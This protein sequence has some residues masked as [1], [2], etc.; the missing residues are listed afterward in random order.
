[1]HQGNKVFSIESLEAELKTILCS[2]NY[3]VAFVGSPLRSD[4]RFGLVLYEELSNRNGRLIKCEY[5]LENCI[6]EILEKKPNVLIVVDAV[7]TNGL[8]PGDIVFIDLSNVKDPPYTLTT[9]NIPLSVTMDL[10]KINGVSSIYLL[11]V[12]VKNLD[13]GLELSEEVKASIGVL[14]SLLTKVMGS[15]TQ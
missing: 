1:M 9:H 7:L 12:T 11:G 2:S 10:L 5:G 8:M 13:V 4:D 15:C 6:Y 14:K 3:V